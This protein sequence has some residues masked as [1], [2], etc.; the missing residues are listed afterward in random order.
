VRLLGSVGE[1]FGRALLGERSVVRDTPASARDVLLEAAEHEAVVLVAHGEVETL[2]DA[3]V[4]C[5]DASG[6]IDRLDVAQLGLSPDAFAGATVLLLSCEGGRMG[7]S[8]V[9]PGGLAGTLLAAGAA[10]VV[11]PLWPVRLDA[12]EQVGRAVLDGMA[13]G[14]EPWTVLARLQ[15]QAH[16]DSPMLG[17]PAPSLSE[18]RAEQ[19]LQR[20]AFVAWIG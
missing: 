2:E 16:G 10:C 13:S 14:D 17:R 4:L 5:L 12:A 11:A 15:V 8:L 18:R 3:A 20:L 19:A 1:R 6:N 9:A 7:D